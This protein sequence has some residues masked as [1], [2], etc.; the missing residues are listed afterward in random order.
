[1]LMDSRTSAVINRR[2]ATPEGGGASRSGWRTGSD[3]VCTGN[4]A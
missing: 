2:D 3:H 4:C 1:M